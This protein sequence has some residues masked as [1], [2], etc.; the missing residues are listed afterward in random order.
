MTDLRNQIGNL[1]AAEKSELIDALWESLEAGAPPLTDI[2][3]AELDRRVEQYER[4]PSDVILGS[5]SG[6][7]CLAMSDAPRRL[8]KGGVFRAQGVRRRGVRPCDLVWGSGSRSP[9]TRQLRA[10]RRI[11]CVSR[12]STDSD[13]V[14]ECGDSST[15]VFRVK[16]GA[17]P[18]VRQRAR[19]V[20]LYNDGERHAATDRASRRPT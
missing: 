18:A 20:R 14:P 12:R 9:W 1:S 16:H 8:D 10:S 15:R 13:G 2:Q 6:R 7:T 11:R 3:C 17:Q 4:D 5:K 19:G